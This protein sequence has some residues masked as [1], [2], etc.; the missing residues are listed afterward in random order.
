[1]YKPTC[2]DPVF[3]MNMNKS[4]FNIKNRSQNG[5]YTM[6]MNTAYLCSSQKDF[7]YVDPQSIHIRSANITLEHSNQYTPAW[8]INKPCGCIPV[9]SVATVVV[10]G[11][12]MWLTWHAHYWACYS[13]SCRSWF[14]Y[15]LNITMCQQYSKTTCKVDC[16]ETCILVI[17]QITYQPDQISEYSS[18]ASTVGLYLWSCPYYLITPIIYLINVLL[19]LIKLYIVMICLVKI[20]W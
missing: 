18:I 9:F 2:W 8:R 12:C 16:G 4:T 10:K 14:K 13:I 11:H 7:Q 5:L 17:S 6:L 3:K 15:H 1:M 19:I 20:S